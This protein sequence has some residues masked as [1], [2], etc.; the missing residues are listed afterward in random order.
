MKLVPHFQSNLYQYDYAIS[1]VCQLGTKLSTTECQVG[2]TLMDSKS[3]PYHGDFKS[4]STLYHMW[5]TLSTCSKSTWYHTSYFT[6]KQCVVLSMSTW[7]HSF[8]QIIIKMI[9]LFQVYVNLVPHIWI[10]IP[11]QLYVYVNLV[12]HQVITVSQVS[13][14]L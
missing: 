6:C 2:T 13:T 4:M 7:Y 14:T 9:M 11:F 8:S 12:P 10:L 5:T 1:N 3:F